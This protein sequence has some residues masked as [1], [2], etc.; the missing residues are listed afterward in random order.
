MANYDFGG[1]DPLGINLVTP[2]PGYLPML[3]GDGN[4]AGA[5]IFFQTDDGRRFWLRAPKKDLVP[6]DLLTTL[7]NAWQPLSSAARLNG[8]R[9]PAIA[10]FQLN[11]SFMGPRV[12]TDTITMIELPLPE[13]RTGPVGV[14]DTET[15]IIDAGIAFWNPVFGDKFRTIGAITLSDP[16]SILNTLDPAVL[17]SI[18]AGGA[19]TKGD[20]D[21]ILSLGTQFS[22][23]IF[24]TDDNGPP[25]VRRT[26]LAHGTAMAD[27][28]C[29]EAQK[30]GKEP[31]LH[32]LEL[33]R[34]VLRDAT[35]DALRNLMPE[36]IVAVAKQ[37]AD[38]RPDLSPFKMKILLAYGFPGG[39]QDVRDGALMEPFLQNVRDRMD[40]LGNIGIDVELVLPMGNH[41]QDRCHTKKSANKEWLN[42]RLLPDDHSANS[43]E[44]L[45]TEGG[46]PS[47]TVLPPDVEQDVSSDLGDSMAVL[48]RDGVNIGAIATNSLADGR[49]LTV[50]TL[51]PTTRQGLEQ[52]EGAAPFGRWRLKVGDGLQ[53]EAWVRRDDSGFEN[54]QGTPKRRSFFED[55]DY[56]ERD[57]FGFP[58]IDD[59]QN[60][61]SDIK[62]GGTASV[63][64]QIISPQITT[65][66]ASW[67]QPGKM[68][69]TALYSGRFSPEQFPPQQPLPV[70]TPDDEPVVDAPGPKSGT[71]CLGNG[72]RRE[73]RASGTSVAAAIKLGNT[74]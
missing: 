7:Q 58:A 40:Q 65:A 4:P 39:P 47:I 11:P 55:S 72:S 22:D 27:L 43:V 25:L 45:H 31:R 28:V 8:E 69:Q 61:A 62:R 70:R 34:S 56:R 3:V 17:G 64:T 23:S 1:L 21:A 33:P 71:R 66:A 38:A 5:S 26:S 57:E 29:R 13:P 59:S 68:S 2:L 41:L 37:A 30:K 52:N 73:F 60:A 48:V 9:F 51:N 53:I 19:T 20:L 24:K 42:W 74:L 49:S 46:V 6:G 54:E 50:F 36:A 14:M 16:T 63:L 15:G 32:G 10:E 12:E 67:Q 18:I 44:L 35:G